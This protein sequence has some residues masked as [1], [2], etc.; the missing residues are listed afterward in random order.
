MLLGTCPNVRAADA[1]NREAV[2][3]ECNME[4]MVGNCVYGGVKRRYPDAA[5]LGRATGGAELQAARRLE[6]LEKL[7]ADGLITPAEY[8]EKLKGL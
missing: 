4:S 2:R 5:I 7:R 8:T 6:T 1:P 3:A